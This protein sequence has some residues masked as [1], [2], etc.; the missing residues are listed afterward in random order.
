MNKIALSNS[1]DKRLQ[2]FDKFTSY[3]YGANVGKVGKTKLLNV[4]SNKKCLIL[5]ILQMKV[6]KDIIDHILQI[7]Y[8]KL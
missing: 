5:M 2:T 7:I 6:K 8:T 4:V 3:P 1:D